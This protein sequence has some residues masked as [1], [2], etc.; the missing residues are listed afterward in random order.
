MRHVSLIAIVLLL[1]TTVSKVFAQEKSKIVFEETEN[2]FG[3]VKETDSIQTVTLQHENTLTEQYPK[4]IG[5]LRATNNHVSFAS[6]KD[7][8]IKTEELEL[9]NDT[10]KP[11]KVD[12]RTVPNYLTATV[13]PDTIP[14]KGK[15]VVKVTLDAKE[16]NS[17]GINSS[18]IY[19]S[20]DGSNDNKYSISIS[21]TIEEDFSELTPEQIINS[22]VAAFSEKDYDF[23]DMRQGD[24]KE[25]IFML[26]NSG[27]TELYIRNVRSSCG[28]V[29]VDLSTKVIETG[30]SV[31]VSVTFDSSGKRGRQSNTITVITNDPKN[32][33]TTLRISCNV[34]VPES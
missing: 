20:L 16:L 13:E 9:F 19:L 15:G 27:K 25:H 28:C 22:P 14:A 21:A 24:K 26:E 1:I 34:V 33:T 5:S 6:M 23:G 29:A 18:R 30:Q 31:P 17:Y 3:S 11:V 10:D 8:E 4:E 7:S 32:P 12:F 2:N